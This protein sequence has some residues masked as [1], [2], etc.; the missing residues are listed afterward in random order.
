MRPE[1]LG[2]GLVTLEFLLCVGLTGPRNHDDCCERKNRSIK[3]RLHRVTP[4]AARWSCDCCLNVSRDELL[5][6][7]KVG[8]T[9]KNAITSA[10]GEKRAPLRPVRQKQKTKRYFFKLRV[11]G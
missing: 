6:C 9:I 11:T 2:A 7:S 4:Y 1:F 8:Q 10:E 3:C 5:V